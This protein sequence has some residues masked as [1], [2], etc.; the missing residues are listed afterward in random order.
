MNSVGKPEDGQQQHVVLPEP[1][2]QDIS[3]FQLEGYAQQFFKTRKKGFFKRTIPLQ[4]V[5]VWSMAR[6][7]LVASF[8][9]EF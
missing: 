3:K 9:S 6:I 1:I 5:L 8:H 7:L 4:E 2:Q